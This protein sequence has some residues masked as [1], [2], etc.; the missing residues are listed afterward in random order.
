MVMD[1]PE[2]R[3]TVKLVGLTVMD[4]TVALELEMFR[5]MPSTEMTAAVVRVTSLPAAKTASGL[6]NKRAPM[7]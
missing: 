2:A 5:V 4:W 1:E 3:V 7:K 6:A